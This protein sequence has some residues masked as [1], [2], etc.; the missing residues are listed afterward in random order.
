MVEVRLTQAKYARVKLFESALK[1]LASKTITRPNYD[2]F[3]K[4][5]CLV[6]SQLWRSNH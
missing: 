5:N 1:A 2:M 6:I 3:S 4:E